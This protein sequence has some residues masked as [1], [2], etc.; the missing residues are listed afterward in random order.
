MARVKSAGS[1]AS[2]SAYDVHPSVTMIQNVIAGMKAKTGRSLEEWIAFV[3]KE[4]PKSSEQRAAWLKAEHGMGTNYAWWIGERAEGK[5]GEDGDPTSYLK[6]AAEYVEAM[7]A[8]PKAALR[9]IHEAVIK[10]GRGLG[11]DVKVCPCS[12]IV[13]LFRNH[14]FAQIKPATRTRIDLGLALKGA[15]EKLPARLIDTGGLKKN[16][17][18]THRIGLTSAKEV[19][20]EVK[21]WMRTAYELD[22]D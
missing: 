4:G 2:K 9:P 10:V 5:G 20:E 15:K 1:K 7:Y 21:R 18:I 6:S 14:V 13:P 3:K 22:G 19:D 17:R 8:G 12:T 11:K 16:D